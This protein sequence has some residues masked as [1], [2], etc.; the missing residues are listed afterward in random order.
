MLK[1]YLVIAFRNLYRQKISSIINIGGLAVGMACV[2]LISLFLQYEFNYDRHHKNSDQIYRVVKGTYEKGVPI[3][4]YTPYTLAETLRNAFPEVVQVTRFYKRRVCRI[5]YGEKRF[6]EEHFV[7][8]DA[9]VFDVFTFPL[10]KGNP[11]DA[12]REPYSVVMTEEIAEKYFGTEDPMGKVISRAGKDYQVTG[13]LQDIPA[14]SHFKIDFLALLTESVL[15]YRDH[16]FVPNMYF[17]PGIY[18]YVLLHKNN[19]SASL[20][21]KFAILAE[22]YKDEDDPYTKDTYTVF[23]YFL[24]SLTRIHFHSH[25]RLELARSGNINFVYLFTA[26]ALL[27]LFV[28]CINFMNI[29]TARSAHRAREVGVRKS[30]AH[31][32][33]NWLGSF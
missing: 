33:G 13:V 10:V 32:G 4:A 18:T 28:A 3:D 14:N 21:E 25:L 24:Q 23:Q 8:A 9:N 12:L 27:I 2:I 22:K 11:D 17:V 31:N 15:D 19:S 5:N 30:W 29:A 20:E 1:N 26:I 7:W 16:P 6:D